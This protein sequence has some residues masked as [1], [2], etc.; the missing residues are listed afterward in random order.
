MKEVSIVVQRLKEMELKERV[1]EEQIN[2][3]ERD[4]SQLKNQKVDKSDL[5]GVF[6]EF[7]NIYDALSIDNKRLINKL[8]FVEIVSFISKEK[9][10]GELEFKIRADGTLKS[11]WPKTANPE[12]L[13]SQLRG[14]WLR[15]QDL[16]LRHPD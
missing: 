15:R 11:N 13:S 2:A 3:L 14:H 7:N 5:H 6:K 10:S 4:I 16:N 12:L 9:K 1:L 8:I